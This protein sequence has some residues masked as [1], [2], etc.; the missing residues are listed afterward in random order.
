MA[1]NYIQPG[2]RITYS[3]GA[4]AVISSGDLVAFGASFGIAAGDIAKSSDGEL[5]TEGV[6]EIPAVTTA[7]IT[8]G[9]PV[10]QVASGGDASPTAEDQ[11]FIGICWK[12]KAEATATVL[13]KIGGYNTTVNDA[14]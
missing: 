3:N 14:A 10:Y 5:I 2:K 4:S 7:E 6:F 8:Q 9:N 1:T 13:V 12:T 11:K